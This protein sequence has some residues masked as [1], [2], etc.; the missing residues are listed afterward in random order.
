M[1]AEKR[2][3]NEVL[4]MVRGGT[5]KADVAH[6]PETLFTDLK[7]EISNLM[8]NTAE[9]VNRGWDRLYY[10]G[11]H[12]ISLEAGDR[13]F[14]L[15]RVIEQTDPLRGAATCYY[16][17]HVEQAATAER[18]IDVAQSV[19]DGTTV[20]IG[21]TEVLNIGRLGGPEA[22]PSTDIMAVLLDEFRECNRI[23]TQEVSK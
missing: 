3:L 2:D 12:Q 16:R 1:F 23:L 13:A 11:I 6:D 22:R 10:V 7:Q 8:T 21:G 15:S 5:Q 20:G 14:K 17:F 19:N 9:L 4:Q 18:A